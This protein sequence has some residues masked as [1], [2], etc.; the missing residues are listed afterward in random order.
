MLSLTLRPAQPSDMQSAPTPPTNESPS[1]PPAKAQKTE[2]INDD[3]EE[4]HSSAEFFGNP[5]N[6]DDY[7]EQESLDEDEL[8]EFISQMEGEDEDDDD[9]DD[10]D[11]NFSVPKE[12][13]VIFG[14]EEVEELPESERPIWTEPLDPS[15]DSEPFS[16]CLVSPSGKTFYTTLDGETFGST[17]DRQFESQNPYVGSARYFSKRLCKYDKVASSKKPSKRGVHHQALASAGAKAYF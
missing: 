1:E 16:T 4:E 8:V 12:D 6:Y 2:V 10:D 9:D 7:L 15:L 5:Y 3:K 13:K 14:D 11:E 17:E